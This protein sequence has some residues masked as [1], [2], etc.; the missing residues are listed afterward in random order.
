[1]A[2]A[3]GDIRHRMDR[4]YRPQGHIYDLTRHYYL[5]GRDLMIAE[6]GARPGQTILDIGCGTG[7]NLALMGQRYP[8]TRLFGLDAAQ[9]MLEIAVRK[10]EQAGVRARLAR[11]VAEELDAQALFGH[12]GGFDHIT[13]SYCLSMVDDPEQAVRA[14]V[15]QLAPGGTLHVVDFGDM[16]GLPRWFG[17][18]MTA[19][20]AR[21]HVR[22]RPE[23]PATLQALSGTGS[24][25]ADA[26]EIMGRYAVLWRYRRVR[27]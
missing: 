19:W 4:R 11:G 12:A 18:A 25:Q 5:L 3:A 26:A 6:L 16:A 17:A 10:L 27:T 20:L 9:P 2:T 14:A 24:G 13:I 7:R 15:R 8:A 22:Y 21:F 23:V 1:M